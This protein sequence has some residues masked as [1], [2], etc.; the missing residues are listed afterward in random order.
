M[1]KFSL[2]IVIQQWD[3]CQLTIMKYFKKEKQE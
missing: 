1:F 2:Q 3:T